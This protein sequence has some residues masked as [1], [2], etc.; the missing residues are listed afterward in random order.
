V[1]FVE[2]ERLLSCVH[3]G[4]CLTSCPTYLELGQESESPR[5]RI[6]LMRALE[7]GRIEPS[8]D[9]ARH[10]DLCLGCRACETACPSGVEY[11]KL[12][13]AA[14]P[15]VEAHRPRAE[16]WRRRALAALLTSP[17]LGAAACAPLRLLGGRR[18]LSRLAGSAPLP[19]RPWLALAAAGPARRRVPPLPAVVEPVGPPRGTAA[20]LLGC[21]PARLFASTQRAA[22]LLLARAGIRVL[23]HA[24]PGCCGAL[25]LH[26]GDTGRA[27]RLARATLEALDVSAVDWIVTSAAGCG[28]LVREYDHLLPDDPRA[29]AVAK[30]TRDVLELL[31]EVGLPPPAGSLPHRVA[32]HDPCHLAH[33]QGVR[34]Q[35]RSLLGAIPGVRLVELD[36]ADTCCGSAGTY[37]LTERAMARRLLA[38]KIDRVVA[39]GAEVVA[40]ANPGCLLQIRAGALARRLAVRVEHPL[41]LLEEAYS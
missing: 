33:G 20:L 29:A 19:L 24:S 22:A 37:N 17:A 27:R 7:E 39:S 28:A 16:R 14:R 21:G 30:R 13:E 10:L 34:A 4:L 25:A 26:L 38:R 36:E 5:G 3:C 15:Y 11:G 32:V 2:A 23:V 35:V 8:A 18:W 40:A 31:G 6:H 41:D 9:V 1:R 12:I